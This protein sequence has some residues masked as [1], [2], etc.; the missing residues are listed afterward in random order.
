MIAVILVFIVIL[1][2]LSARAS[3]LIG[4][5]IPTSFLLGILML[6]MAGFTIN[7]VVLFSLILAVGMLVDDAIIVTEFAERR[8]SE[9]MNKEDAYAL[10]ARRMAGPVIAATH[11]ARRRLLAAAVLAGHRRRI[12]EVSADHAD[13]HAVGLDALCAGFHADARLDL[14]Q[15]AS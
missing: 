12:H 11:D 14:R 3:L 15:G 4:L 8:M 6:A 2:S 9:G 13:R 7:I 5:A 10:A 1:Y